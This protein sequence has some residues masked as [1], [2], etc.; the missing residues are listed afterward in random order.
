MM[1]GVATKKARLHVDAFV[2]LLGED[3]QSWGLSHKGNIASTQSIG[4]IE[5]YITICGH[6]VQLK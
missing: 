6:D 4:H 3:S 2:N 1:F 5:V